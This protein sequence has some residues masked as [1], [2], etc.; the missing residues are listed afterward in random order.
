MRTPLVHAVCVLTLGS[1]AL[2]SAGCS[3]KLDSVFRDN[4]VPE[5]RLTQAPVN[6]QD[7]YFYAYRMNWVGYD[8]DGRVDHYLIA[9]DPARADSV[10]L[11]GPHAW[12]R[13]IKNEEIIFFKAGSPDSSTQ[14]ARAN[15]YHTFAIAAVD[16]Q[17]AL[18]K[19]V[20]RSFF[21][22]TEAPIV[23]VET[24]SPNAVF[25]P[26]VTPVVRISW[27]GIDPDGQFTTKPVK[28]KFRL[29]GQHNPDFPGI[30]T[31][32]FVSFIIANPNFI[33]IGRAHV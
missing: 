29:F 11:T 3:H 6:T 15:D 18:S 16:N 22:Y 27:R 28:Y 19:P 4:M 14:F 17:G 8:P 23:F 32:D 20:W 7:Q 26:I 1:L 21:S 5:V 31:P 33:Q 2:T 10:E 24:P 12:T 30:I 9:V 25:T 13:T